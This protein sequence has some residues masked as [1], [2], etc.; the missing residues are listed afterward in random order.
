MACVRGVTL[1]PLLDTF[2]IQNQYIS[3]LDAVHASHGAPGRVH[4]AVPPVLLIPWPVRVGAQWVS[5]N[6]PPAIV[7]KQLARIVRGV[8]PVEDHA[9]KVKT[10]TMWPPI[11]CRQVYQIKVLLAVVKQG[12]VLLAAMPATY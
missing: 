7:V 4:A 3:D 5:L 8:C 10:G 6:G 9:S 12:L 2:A 11:T 1:Q